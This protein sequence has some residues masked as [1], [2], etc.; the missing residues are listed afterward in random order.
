MKSSVFIVVLF[1]VFLWAVIYFKETR[2]NYPLRVTKVVEVAYT[3]T[4]LGYQKIWQTS[5]H[6]YVN[7]SQDIYFVSDTAFKMGAIIK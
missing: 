1:M 3:N 6:V 2:I 7:Q 4:P 5:H